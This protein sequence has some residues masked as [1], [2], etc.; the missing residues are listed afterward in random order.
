M[1][2]RRQKLQLVVVVLVQHIV[3]LIWLASKLYYCSKIRI[4]KYL[5]RMIMGPL[6]GSRYKDIL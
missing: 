1:M 5:N 6:Q 3:C 4:K 2:A